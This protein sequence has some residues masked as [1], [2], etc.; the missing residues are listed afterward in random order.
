MSKQKGSSSYFDINGFTTKLGYTTGITAIDLA[1]YDDPSIHGTRN[2]NFGIDMQDNHTHLTLDDLKFVSVLTGEEKARFIGGGLKVRDEN[3]IP[4]PYHGLEALKVRENIPLPN[5]EGEE[6]AVFRDDATGAVTTR[7][8]DTP[9]DDYFG[10]G[11]IW[12]ADGSALKFISSR[13]N[14]GIPIYLP[15]EGKVIAGPEGANWRMWSPDD[16]DVIYLMKRKDMTFYVSSWNRKNREEKAIAHFTVP[17]VGSYVEFKRFTPLGNIIVGFRE[18]PHLYIIDVHHNEARYIKLPTRLKDVEVTDNED[19][20][21]WAVCYTYERPWQNLKTGEH[22]L[23]PSFS[24]GHASWGKNGM[25]ANFGG[26]LNVFVPGDIGRTYTPGDLIKVWANWENDIVTDYGNLTVDNQ[27]VFTNGT[28]GDVNHQHLMIPSSDPGAVMRVARYFTKFSWTSTT[29]SRPSPDYTKL[30]YNENDIGNTELYMVYVRRPDPP[31]NVN[32]TGNTLSWTRPERSLEIAGYNI[33]GS[34]NSGRGFT[35]INTEYIS[36]NTYTVD[37]NWKYYA[38]SSL[39]HSGLESEFSDEVSTNGGR[40]FYFEAEDMMLTPPARHFFDGYCNNFQCVRINAESDQEKSQPGEV[41]IPSG[42]LESGAYNIWARVKGQG[43][44][45]AGSEPVNISGEEWTWVKLGRYSAG[46]SSDKLVI[47]SSDDD[48]RLDL[49]LLT[50]DDFTPEAPYPCDSNPPAKV[51]DLKAI[52]SGKQVRLSW[53][54]NNDLDLHH[55]SV[56]CGDTPDFIC[57]NTTIIRSVLK[58]GITDVL[59][60]SPRGKYYKVVAYDNRWNTSIPAAIRVD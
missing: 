31:L 33:Y 26:H 57:D 44:W 54:A 27:Y 8:T 13:K 45:S 37:Q 34:N 22:G 47:S 25:V 50:K 3:L 46:N 28:R 48:L 53:R 39:E 5:P 24:A 59:P 20:V 21:D 32:L 7:L 12:S 19:V 30:I 55:Y 10:E 15:G 18:T 23:M 42:G 38:V 36:G 52:A 49:V 1:D 17:E 16:P 29:Y 35:R 43:S 14:G 9:G 56:Y 11:G 40:S 2:V 58:T 41:N 6:M 51:S 4:R 60:A